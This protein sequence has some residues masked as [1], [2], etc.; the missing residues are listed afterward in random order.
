MYNID[1]I[2]APTINLFL[3]P[4]GTQQVEPGLGKLFGNIKRR[5]SS[6]VQFQQGIINSYIM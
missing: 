1:D 5:K 3:L 4:Q 2:P 6:I